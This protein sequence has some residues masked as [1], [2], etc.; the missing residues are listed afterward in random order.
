[1]VINRL[2]IA[3]QNEFS[4]FLDRGTFHCRCNL[5]KNFQLRESPISLEVPF[6]RGRGKIL[7][8]GKIWCILENL[9]YIIKTLKSPEKVLE[10]KNFL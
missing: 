2:Q 9:H 1:M 5:Y 8:L 4:I 7:L 10:N 3:T 6:Y